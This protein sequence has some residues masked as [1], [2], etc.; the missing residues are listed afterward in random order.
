MEQEA[1]EDGRAAQKERQLISLSKG[2]LPCLSLLVHFGTRTVE[3]AWIRGLRVVDGHAVELEGAATSY[4]ALADFMRVLEED[5]GF[6]RAA[7]VLKKSERKQEAAGGSLI[8]FSLE[9]KI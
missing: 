2:A 4:D 3:G 1:Q 9:L 5:K 6:F 8:Y 7:P